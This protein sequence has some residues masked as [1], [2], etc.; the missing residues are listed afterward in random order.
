MDAEARPLNA[1]PRFSI[2]TVVQQDEAFFYFAAADPAN[3][4]VLVASDYHSSVIRRVNLQ[5]GGPQVHNLPVRQGS[6]AA[7][8]G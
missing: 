3:P 7:V 6:R 2:A 4:A 5:D 1:P 8:P